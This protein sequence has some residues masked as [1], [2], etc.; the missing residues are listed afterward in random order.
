MSCTG[1]TV[2]H[3]VTGKRAKYYPD[4]YVKMAD[5]VIR[6]LEI[7]PKKQT[8]RPEQPKRK[9]KNYINEVETWVTNQ[10]KWKS[11]KYYCSKNNMQ[12]EVWTEDTL[13]E[14]GIMKSPKL[15]TLNER[16]KVTRPRPTTP[17]RPRPKR[18]S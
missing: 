4:F 3:P 11:A 18:R 8:V 15:K 17:K 12:F 14:M 1:L 9:T 7:K 10:E 6:I 13:T 16:K 5:G 2:T